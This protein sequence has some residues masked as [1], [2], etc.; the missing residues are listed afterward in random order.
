MAEYRDGG[1]QARE[2]AVSEVENL[3]Y[4]FPRQIIPARLA[5]FEAGGEE[6]AASREG[7]VGEALA[8]GNWR[9]RRR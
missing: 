2:V 3:A 4:L 7:R 5:H 6:Q 8:H 9:S 1:A